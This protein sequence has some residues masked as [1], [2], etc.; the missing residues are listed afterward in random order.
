VNLE[1]IE[2]A[3]Y[4][5]ALPAFV[6]GGVVFLAHLYL[7][8]RSAATFWAGWVFTLIGVLALVGSLTARSFQ[9]ETPRLPLTT[10]F[11]I[12][13]LVQIGAAGTLLVVLPRAKELRLAGPLVLAVV[14]ALWAYGYSKHREIE[15]TLQPA[16]KSYWLQ[17]HVATAVLSYGPLFMSGVTSIMAS[18]MYLIGGEYT[19]QRPPEEEG[20]EPRPSIADRFEE[21]TYRIIAFGFPWLTALI[22]TGAIWAN[23]AWGRAWGFDPKEMWSA[24]TWFIYVAYLHARLRSGWRGLQASLL[25]AAG[26][27]AMIVTYVLVNW[28]VEVFQVESLHTYSD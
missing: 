15:E 7:A 24:I 5:A 8:G 28:I 13:V 10:M 27:L 12:T 11:E 2:M 23:Y 1:L 3:L 4:Q 20:G 25:A 21:W 9:P 18:V 6:L 14:A 19:K 16:L 17:I 22:V 26:L